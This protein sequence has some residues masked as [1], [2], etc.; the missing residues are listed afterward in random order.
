MKV[1]Y[2]QQVPYR[3]LPDDFEKRYESVVT[4]PYSLTEP[5]KVHS[6]FRDSLDE[7]MHAARAGFD[8]ITITEHSQSAYDMLPNP[9]LMESA[10]AYATEVEGLKTGIFPVGRS[11]GKSREPLRVAE[12]MAMLDA[13]S[14]GRLIAGFPV[15]LAYD[16]NVNN[17]VSPAE[18]R[19][20]FDENLDLVLRAWH[21]REPFAWNGRFHQHASVNIWPRP[22]QKSPPVFITGIGNPRT[23][24]FCLQNGF[25]FNYF[26]WFGAKA[27][28]KRIFDRF[29]DTAQRLGK[30]DN[31]YQMGFMQTVCVAETDAQAEKLFAE[32]AEYFF[33]KGLGSIPMHRLSLPGGI[34]IKGLEF[35]FR[36]PG[37]FGIYAKMREASFAEL[38]DAGAVICG[39]PA[40]VREQITTFA[41]DFRIGNLHAMLQFGS[42]PHELAKDNINLFAEEVMPH[43]RDIWTD[44]GWQHHWWPEALGGVPAA[45]TTEAVSA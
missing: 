20:R 34:D 38:V 41:R 16:A 32:H 14:N 43:L 4:T 18:T 8:A 3:H 27:A 24:E 35:I 7:I 13:I 1:T 17:G 10:V 42:M 37:D 22:I 40:T 33:R 28:G 2:F 30:D 6:A 21:E 44:E 36:D 25:G 26:G 15:G 31:P 12:E 5:D 19:L 29:W 23:M 39:S 9:S 11:L 45:T